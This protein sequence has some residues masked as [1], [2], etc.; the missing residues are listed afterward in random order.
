MTARTRRPEP[1]PD[2]PPR[3]ILYLHSSDE[4]Y[5]SDRMLLALVRGLDR[6][7]YR[8]I[9]ALPTDLPY[10]GLLS[11]ELRASGVACLKL[12]LAVV[13]RR[14][15]TPHG[16]LQFIGRLLHS[17]AR[18]VA[19][20]RRERVALVHSNTLVVWPG[21]LAALLTRRPHVWHIHE[22]LGG[23]ARPR[24]LIGRV[25]LALATAVVVNS[26]ALRAAL[27]S[28]RVASRRVAI[29]PN[30]IALPPADGAGTAARAR[31]RAAWG[32]EGDT[33]VVGTVGRV[34]RRKGQR[35]LLHAA[36]RVL[37]ADAPIHVVIIGGPVP[38]Q[39][40][41][42]DDLN[43]QAVATGL[44]GRATFTGFRRDVVDLLP[45]FDVFVLPSVLPESFG[46][47]VIEAM[48]AGLPVVAT[49]SGG[50]SEA[51]VDGETGLLVPPG[52][53]EA[54]AGALARVLDDAGLR[55]RFGQAGRIRVAAHFTL[56]AYNMKWAALY[57]RLLP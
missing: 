1:A 40:R 46:L 33:Q 29:I 47:V 36:A 41:L 20:I 32:V 35:E 53:I 8:P 55:E 4:L 13:R 49:R 12:D 21:A 52:D 9:V 51:V 19:L 30:A 43:A 28:P 34:S 3:T 24:L 17:T 54:L 26:A 5:G 15:L 38:G 37:A 27:F 31:A 56:D 16:G 50:P 6:A 57:A 14:Y 2:P 23:P 22:L 25:L 18:L 44:A 45:A 48:A 11:A 10:E 39:E 42:L 7:R